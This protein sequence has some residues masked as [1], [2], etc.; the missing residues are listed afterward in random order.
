MPLLLPDQLDTPASF[1]AVQKAGSLLGSAGLI[2]LDDT[3]LHG[4]A[5]DEPA[6]LLPPRVVRQVHAMP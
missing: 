2:V 5:R 1:D 6:A 3:R 4:V